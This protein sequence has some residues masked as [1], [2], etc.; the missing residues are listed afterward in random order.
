MYSYN[1]C[2]YIYQKVLLNFLSMNNVMG[3]Y[4]AEALSVRNKILRRALRKVF[5]R[6]EFCMYVVSIVAYQDYQDYPDRCRPH[7]KK[8]VP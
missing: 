6:K 7:K 8:N 4:K 5:Q 1:E 3:N 2:P